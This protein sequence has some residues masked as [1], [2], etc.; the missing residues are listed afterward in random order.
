[1]LFEKFRLVFFLKKINL[2]FFKNKSSKLSFKSSGISSWFVSKFL[3][4]KFIRS[5]NDVL[6]LTELNFQKLFKYQ[7]SH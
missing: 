1:M 6:V 3:K 5:V 2:I 7:F 4:L